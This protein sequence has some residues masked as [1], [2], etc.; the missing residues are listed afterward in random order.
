MY[1]YL[2]GGYL[3]MRI[4]L[5]TQSEN[6]Y[7]PAS[8]ARICRALY[9]D[10]VCIVSAP[11]M[12]THGGKVKG[13][14][15]HFHLFGAKGTAIMASRIIRARLKDLFSK[16][17][18][19]RPFYSIKT[20]AD[21]F[22]IP[23][24][25]VD[26]VKGVRFQ[27]VLDRYKPELL[28]SV[29]CPQIIGKKIRE[30]FPR[31]CINV[32]GAPLPRYRGLMPAFW[33]LRNGEAKT[34][35]TVHDLADKLDNGDILVQ[36]EVEIADSDTWDSLVCKTKAAGAEALIEAVKRIKDGSVERHPNVDSEATYFSFPTAKDR[37][38]FL[39]TGRRFF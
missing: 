22:A 8:F 32:H 39:K 18:V 14:L 4:L 24:E 16:P 10:I 21:G 33:A 12:S 3:V 29:S 6:L 28:I 17:N 36:R 7:L 25:Q 30:Q 27:R 23:F 35:V 13:F 34:A 15:R 37:K 2:S 26:E 31:G 11:A 9:S 19:D 1:N 5:L 20:V 38:V